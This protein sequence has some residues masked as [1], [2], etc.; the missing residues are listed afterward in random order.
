MNDA[1]PPEAGELWWLFPTG[2][3]A[4]SGLFAKLATVD[5]WVTIVVAASMG[6]VI[7]VVQRIVLDWRRTRWY[8][9][10]PEAGHQPNEPQP[11]PT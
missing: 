11:P 8:L 1:H 3:A 10:H 2:L 6:L 9:S 4:C 5:T 7:V